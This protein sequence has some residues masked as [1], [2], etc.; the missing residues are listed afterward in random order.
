[1]LG[2][3]SSH[4]SE[5]TINREVDH[6]DLPAAGHRLAGAEYLAV[7]QVDKAYGI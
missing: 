4:T 2:I 1:M 6:H 3:K 5:R 7:S